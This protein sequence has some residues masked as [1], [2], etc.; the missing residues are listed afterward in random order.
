MKILSLEQV[1]HDLGVGASTV[2]R[3]I[4]RGEFVAPVAI[5]A[6]RIGFVEAEVSDWLATRPRGPSKSTRIIQRKS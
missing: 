4:D 3:M 5:S 2:R 1:A 6:R